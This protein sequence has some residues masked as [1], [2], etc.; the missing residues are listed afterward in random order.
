MEV[1]TTEPLKYD[2]SKDELGAKEELSE[3]SE[4]ESHAMANRLVASHVLTFKCIGVTNS[5]DYQTAL[6]KARDLIM[7][8]QVVLVTLVHEPNNPCESRPLAF[9]CHI[10]DK[11]HTIAYVVSEVVEVYSTSDAVRCCKY[12]FSEVCLGVIHY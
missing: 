1:G 2:D 10:E 3:S 9:V 7:G 5:Q 6:R 11:Q 4:E 8:G 12:C